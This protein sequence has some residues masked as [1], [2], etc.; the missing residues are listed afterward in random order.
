ME[1]KIS[2]PVCGRVK[3]KKGIFVAF[4]IT[5]VVVPEDSMT[6]FL[7]IVCWKIPS[8]SLL[9]FWLDQVYSLPLIDC[10]KGQKFLKSAFWSLGNKKILHAVFDNAPYMYIQDWFLLVGK[11]VCG[12]TLNIDYWTFFPWLAATKQSDWFFKPASPIRENIF[13]RFWHIHKT[14][15]T[16]RAG[17]NS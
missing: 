8:P 15:C 10:W 11:C 1:I 12:W 4:L 3:Q 14:K 2:I 7:I 17:H 16:L 6:C 5:V 9:C 13:Q